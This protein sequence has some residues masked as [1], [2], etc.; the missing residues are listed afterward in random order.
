MAWLSALLTIVLVA[1]CQHETSPADTP[2]G[3][4]SEGPVS[5]VGSD[6][7]FTPVSGLFARAGDRVVY[8]A[9]TIRNAGAASA[10]LRAAQLV[11]DVDPSAATISSMRVVDLS[12]AAHDLVGAAQWP[13]EDFRERSLPLEDF[14]LLPG[15]EAEVLIVVDVVKTGDW[16]WPATALT[17]EVDGKDFRTEAPFGFHICPSVDACQR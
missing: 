15:H 9:T 10:T 11:G 1:G 6:S 3:K 16:L 5:F 13:Y 8:G 17:Y 2:R 12:G 14:E 4:A 7:G